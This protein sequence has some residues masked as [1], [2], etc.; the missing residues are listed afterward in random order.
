MIQDRHIPAYTLMRRAGEAAWQILRQEWPAVDRTVVFCGVGNNGGD[1]LVL[2][3]HVVRAGGRVQV[4]SLPGRRSDEAQLA[5]NAVAEQHVACWPWS[6]NRV[7]AMDWSGQDTVLVDALFGTGLSRDIT[8]PAQELIGWINHSGLPVLSLDIPS[9]LHPDTGVPQ[10]HAVR[11]DVTVSFIGLKRGLY[12]GQGAEYCRKVHLTDLGVPEALHEALPGPLVV[13]RIVSGD[14]AHWLQ[15]R[16]RAAHKGDFGRVL[17]IGGDSPYL[18]A[19]LMAATASL[20][21]GAGLVNVLTRPE[22]A[23]VLAASRPE[24]IVHGVALGQDI[25]DLLSTVSVVAI[26]PGLG[27]STWAEEILMQVLQC[28]QP[29]V[30]DADAL[31]LFARY[32]PASRAT[33]V[34]TPHPGEAGRLLD[35]TTREVQCDRVAAVQALQKRYGGVVVLKGS[36]SLV[37]AP[38]EAPVTVVGDQS[39]SPAGESVRVALSD[40]GNPGMATAGMGDVLCGLIAAL[41]AQGLPLRVAAEYGV[42]LHGDAGDRA[43]EQ[44]GERGMLAADVLQLLREQ[45]NPL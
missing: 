29:L 15:P 42:C 33:W 45:V 34:L 24:L 26:G 27:Q 39:D 31:N 1:G 21:A 19:I 6:L 35:C 22:H 13:Q 17:L 30:V 11:A 9:G 40:S 4:L 18:G 3:E 36:G 16:Q 37:A 10:G 32:R 38:L 44:G 20:R 5:Y 28:P 41:I 25:Q 2:A 43:S 7:R 8:G 12:T 14:Y 23:P